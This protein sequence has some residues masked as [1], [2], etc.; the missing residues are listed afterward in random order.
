MKNKIFKQLLDLVNEEISGIYDYF[1]LH[2]LLFERKAN[3]IKSDSYGGHEIN[4][5]MDEF[6]QIINTKSSELLEKISQMFKDSGRKLSKKQYKELI[7][8]CTAPFISCIDNYKQVFQNEFELNKTLETKLEVAKG[9]I[10]NKISNHIN[11]LKIFINSKLDK[12]L[13][14]T[15]IGTIFAGV[16][17]IL[18]VIAIITANS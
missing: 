1:A 5:I 10:S 18:S 16:S 12:A 2:N 13:W 15:A 6:N 9:N 7:K 14:W 8:N 17:L 11:A 3:Q 4:K